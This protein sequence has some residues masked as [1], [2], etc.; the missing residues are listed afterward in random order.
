[1][2]SAFFIYGAPAMAPLQFP[3]LNPRMPPLKLPRAGFHLPCPGDSPFC[4]SIASQYGHSFTSF[5]PSG[6]CVSRAAKLREQ[7][8]TCR[9]A[10]MALGGSGECCQGTG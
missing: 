8:L 10:R 3:N 9:E 7:E 6:G 1:V 4:P 2:A 5:R